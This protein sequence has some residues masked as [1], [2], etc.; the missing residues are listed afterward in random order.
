MYLTTQ[1]ELRVIRWRDVQQM[2]QKF[3]RH[4]CKK[5]VRINENVTIIPYSQYTGA[6]YKCSC[7]GCKRTNDRFIKSNL[8]KTNCGDNKYCTLSS[9]DRK[10]EHSNHR[11][12]SRQR[13][14]RRVIQGFR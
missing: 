1:E 6:C 12:P 8:R 14:R 7:I 9:F 5:K 3:Q 13:E 2:V 11:L 10:T 4:P